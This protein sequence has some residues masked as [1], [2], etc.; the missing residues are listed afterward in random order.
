MTDVPGSAP[1]NPGKA[2]SVMSTPNP[3][4]TFVFNCP[5]GNYGNTENRICLTYNNVT[6]KDPLRKPNDILGKPD[7]E[8]FYNFAFP[9][10]VGRTE[11]SVN[12]R[13]FEPPPVSM[14]TQPKEVTTGC[15]DEVCEK[16]GVC[17]CTYTEKIPSNKIIQMIFMNLG[18][19]SGWSHPIHLHGHSFYVMKMGLPEYDPITGLLVRP[20]RDINCTDI[21]NYCNKAAWSNPE[22][23]DGNIADLSDDPPQKDT[24]IVP[25]GM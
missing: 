18:S 25:T 4:H 1:P 20:T 7:K 21:H 13:Q 16:E 5:F 3:P 12:G 2:Q 10:P 6:N 8:Y 17:T 14:L 19:G 11:G 24:I 9:G 22:W 15:N 23:A